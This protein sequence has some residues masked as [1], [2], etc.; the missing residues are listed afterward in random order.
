MF[1]S[2]IY[3]C[4]SQ[5]LDEFDTF[6]ENFEFMLSRMSA[7]EPYCVIIIGDFNCRS[8]QW[9]ENEHENDEGRLFEPFTSELGVQ[10]LICEPTHFI[11]ESKSCI[12]LLFTN[13]PHL[14]LEIG[15][16]QTLHEQCHHHIVFAKI[17]A[18]N[19]APPP[20][21]RKFGIMIKQIF[22]QTL[23]RTKPKQFGL[24]WHPG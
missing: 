16:H 6:K 14:F 12:D 18:I 1:L 7:E 5:T 24:V 15:V 19:L 13:Q 23:S 9:W 20:Y 22:S 10:Q 21:N 3:R 17:T 2:L 8:P 4:P 11:G